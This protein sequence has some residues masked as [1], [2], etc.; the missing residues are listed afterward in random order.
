MAS[1]LSKSFVGMSRPRA[2]TAAP[3]A[4]V[5]GVPLDAR[6]GGLASYFT[7]RVSPAT[8]G[9]PARRGRAATETAAD[10]AA[11]VTTAGAAA[12][13]AAARAVRRALPGAEGV[14]RGTAALAAP[15]V[16]PE[17][18]AR[19]GGMAGAAVAEAVTTGRGAIDTARWLAAARTYVGKPPASTETSF[20]AKQRSSPTT[21][22]R[23]L[24]SAC[25]EMHGS[26]QAP[27]AALAEDEV[28][29]AAVRGAAEGTAA[30]E[31]T[32]E[33]VRRVAEAPRPAPRRTLRRF[34]GD[35]GRAITT[36]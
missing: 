23:H 26:L 1:I 13:G 15:L 20:R 18:A 32:E 16:G 9:A 8:R 17:Q 34:F 7:R 6:R 5:A 35:V 24:A 14:A 27:A 4:N 22:I 29:A 21:L 3:A 28:R 25:Q 19:I 10:A 30:A 11:V 36:R 31:A 2:A 12:A 33:A